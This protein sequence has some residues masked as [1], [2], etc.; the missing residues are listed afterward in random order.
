MNQNEKLERKDMLV[1]ELLAKAAIS[2]SKMSA[3]SRCCYIYHQPKIPK[4]LKKLR[5]F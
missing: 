3:N 4:D 5:K 1:G 2:V